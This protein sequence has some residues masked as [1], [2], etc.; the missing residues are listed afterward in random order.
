VM[1]YEIQEAQFPSTKRKNL[2]EPI[3]TRDGF[4]VVT[5]ITQQ[6]FENL[7]DALRH[8]EWKSD[9]LLS[10]QA[11]RRENWTL[12]MNRVRDWAAQLGCE[13]C[14]ALL[15]EAGVPCSRYA[16]VRE[17]L[18]DPQLAFRES[19]ASVDDGAGPYQIQNLPF[20][21]SGAS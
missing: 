10:T 5:P 12:L 11:A 8:P 17:A 7:C 13:E 21:M 3:R 16:T 2:Y 4:V 9:P 20:L 6:N 18:A 14:E 1:V 15:L 19:F